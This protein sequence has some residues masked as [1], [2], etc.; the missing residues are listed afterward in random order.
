MAGNE[1]NI[2]YRRLLRSY[3]S[4]VISI[5]LVLFIVGMTGVLIANARSVSNYFRE[6]I[7][8]SAVLNVEADEADASALADELEQGGYVRDIRI[9]TKEEGVEEMKQ[10]LGEDF[11]DVFEVNPIPVSLDIQVAAD[12][13]NTDSLLVIEK[14]IRDYPVVEDVV[15]QQ[16]LVELLNANIERI[17]IIAGVFVLLLL[18][19]S[20]VLINNTV[21]LNVYA[22]RFTIHTMRLVGA[23][24]GFIVR[25]FVGQAFFQGLISGA[26]ADVL[27]LGALYMIRNEFYQLFSL[28]DAVLLGAVMAGVVLLGIVIC[29]LSTISGVRSQISL[30]KNELYY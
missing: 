27:I 19:I 21:R 4:S 26:V 28:F 25:P 10:I 18:F 20:V 11:M 13:I 29:I 8:V 5:S 3:F 30:T 7:T 22:K 14:A 16:S 24:K 17:G 15:Y 1:S 12:Y 6:N 9:V 2:L 23:T